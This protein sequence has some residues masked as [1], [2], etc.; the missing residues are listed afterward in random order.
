M[1]TTVFIVLAASA[2]L[3]C[4]AGSEQLQQPDAAFC[5]RVEGGR[6]VFHGPYVAYWPNG[7]VQ[8]Q[9]Q[10]AEGFRDGH[11]RFF[12][13]AGVATGDTWF[14]AGSYHGV[15][16]ELYANGQKRLEEQW[17]E[18]KRQGPQKRWDEKG[19]LTIVEYRDDRPAH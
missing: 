3:L 7:A 1:L 19:A 11:W 10:Y 15:R 14:K 9:G 18:G 2:R 6:R 16:I 5:A 13:A 17:V 8:S 4:P 12:D